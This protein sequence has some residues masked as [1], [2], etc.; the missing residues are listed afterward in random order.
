[1]RGNH[2]GSLSYLMSP[3]RPLTVLHGLWAVLAGADAHRVLDADDEDLAVAHLTLPRAARDRQLV[4]HGADDLRSHHRLDLQ[5]RAQRNV[6]RPS[7]V[8]LGVAALRAATLDLGDRDAGNSA[9]VQHVL[10]L[11]Q[12]LVADDR[13]DHLHRVAASIRSVRRHAGDTSWCAVAAGS[14][15]WCGLTVGVSGWR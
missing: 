1:M 12:A 2:P 13:H 9:L 11:L 15:V 5:A 7:A 10:D 6:H 8:G 4:D 3:H 14:G